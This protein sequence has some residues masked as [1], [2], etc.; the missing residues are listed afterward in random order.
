M[1]NSS[2]ISESEDA[3]ETTKM[4]ENSDSEDTGDKETPAV[5]DLNELFDHSALRNLVSKFKEE[6]TENVLQQY[7]TQI[8]RWLD[9]KDSKQE[10]T[11]SIAQFCDWLM[12]KSVSRDDAIKTF[13]QFDTDGS[14]VVETSTMIET[15]KSMSGPNL[16]GELG[17]SIR[18]MQA[19]SLT[20]GFVDVYAGDKNAVKQHAEKILK[21]L[22]RN[23][24]PSSFLPFPLLNGFN[25]T[26]NMRA[27]VLKHVF[28]NIKESGPSFTQEGVLGSGEE[29]RTISPCHSN[30]EVSSNSSESYRLTNGDPNTYWQ[31]DGTARS[32]WI[33]LHTKT[34][35]VIKT[36]SVAVASS[37]SS[38][39]PELIHIVAGKN[40]RSLR[41]LKEIRI[42]SHVTGDVVLLKN[43]KIYYPIIQINI[44]R[45]RNDGCDTRIHGI[46]TV[47]YKVMKELGINV[48]DAAAVWYIQILA[49]TVTMT[50]PLNPQLRPMVLEHT[51]R[52]LDNIPPLSLCPASTERPKFL[53]KY[54]LQEV[55][56]FVTDI[57]LSNDGEVVQ[58]GL[59]MLLSFNLARGNVGGILRTLKLLQEFPETNLPCSEL[60]RKMLQ[61]RDSCWE[62]SGHQLPVTILGT[63]G[64]KSDDN[65]GPENLL[66]HTWTSLPVEAF[67]TTEDGKTKCNIIFKSTE[68]IQIT[69][70]RLKNAQGSKGVRRGLLF[71][72]RDSTEKFNMEEHA[73]R[74]ESYDDWG[75]MEYD[76]SVQVRGAGIAGKPDNPVAYFTFEDDCN[77]IDIPVTWHPVGQYILIKLLEP[78]Q[79]KET[80]LSVAGVRFYGFPR[81]Q[82]LIDEEVSVKHPP[83]PDKKPNCNSLEII[84]HVLEFIVDLAQ[85][86]VKKGISSGKSD[87]LEF[88]DT[89]IDTLWELYT[90]FR[91]NDQEKWQSCAILMLQL[92]YCLLPV[93]SAPEGEK[94]KCS[95]EMF[96][97][98]CKVIDD[99]AVVKTSKKYRLCKQLIVEGAAM[100][101]P[102]KDARRKQLFSMMHHV[103]NLSKSPSVMLVFQSLC[104]FFSSVDPSGLLELPNHV[105]ED[106]NSQ[107]VLDIME[108]M[109]SVTYH[110]FTDT[111]DTGECHEQVIH[112]LEL[113]CSLQTSLLSWCWSHMLEEETRTDLQKEKVI[114]IAYQY[115]MSVAKKG[116]NACKLLLKQSKEKLMEF[117][118]IPNSSFLGNIIRQLIMML[119]YICD[120][121]GSTARVVLIHSFQH[122]V[123][124]LNDLAKMLPEIFPNI[125]SD[126]WST[127]QTDDIVLR[128]WEVESSHSYHNNEHET[129]VFSCPGA[130]RFIIDFDPRCETERRYDYLMFTDATGYQMKFDQRVGSNKWPRQVQ[131]TGPHVHFLFHSDNSNTEWG[132]KFKVTARGS[133]DVPLSWPF[134]LQLSLT[135]LMG[136]LCGATLASNSQAVKT[137]AIGPEDTAEQDVLRSELWTTLFRGGYMIGKL[138]HSLSGKFQAESSGSVLE[139]LLEVIDRKEG[140]PL[141]LIEKCRDH[142]KGLQVGGETIENAVIAVFT[143]LIWHT[144]QL[145]E[146]LQKYIAVS[147]GDH[148]VSDG[149]LHA[150]STAESI[151]MQLL[152]LKQKIAAAEKEEENDEEPAL[153]C[154]DKAMYLLK[155]AGLTK[156][157]LKNEMRSK[158]AKQWKKLSNKKNEKIKL[159]VTDKYPSFRLVLEFVQDPA[160]TTERVNRMI[161]ERVNHAKAVSDVYSF[162]AEFL[163]I[164]CLSV[165][166][167]IFQIPAVL[168]FQE[169]LS[170]QDGFAKHYAD[171][172]DGCGLQQEAKV[173]QAY[174]QLIRRLSEPFHNLHKHDLDKKIMPAYEFIQTCLLHLLDIEWQAYDLTFVTE[175]KLPSLYLD[176][177]KE[178][179]KMR[180]CMVDHQDED[181][182]L[183]EYEKFIKWFEDCSSGFEEW[184]E[185]NKVDDP[186]FKEE[187]RQVQMFVARFCDL[188]EVEISCDGCGV[189]LPG[190]RY[191]CLQCS[192]MDLCATCFAGGVKPEGDHGDDHEFVH[193]VYKCNMCQAFIV[194]T[195]IHCNQCEDFDLCIGCHNKGSYPKEHNTDHDITKFPMIKLKTSQ[196]SDS[197]IQ[198][199]IHQHVWLLFTVQALATGDIIHN[200]NQ[201][202]DPDYIKL[203]AQLQSQ[204][205]DAVTHCL[206]QVPDDAEDGSKDILQEGRSLEQRQEEAFAIHSQERVMGLLGAMIPADSKSTLPGVTFNFSTV[207]FIQLLFK[208]A[209]GESGHEVNTQHLAMGLLGPLLKKSSPKVADEAVITKD[210]T[211]EVEGQKSIKYLFSF[212]A[213]CLEKWGLEWACSVA[214]ILQSLYISS[215]WKMVIHQHLTH[216]VLSMTDKPDLQSIFAL[217]VMAG[218]PEVLTIGTLVHF[219]HIGTEQ[220]GVV[221]KHFPDKYQT[222][223]IDIKTRKRHTINDKFIDCLSMVTEVWDTDHFSV[224]IQTV[225]SI[226][227][228]IKTDEDISVEAV[229]VLSLSLKVL[230]N[231][232]KK[233]G[234]TYYATELFEASFIQCLVYLSSKGTD[235]SQQWLIKDLEVLS[236]MLY[237]DG[238][239]SSTKKGRHP[240]FPE[241]PSIVS[242]KTM[243]SKDK[244]SGDDKESL[245][246][247]SSSSISS[248]PSS[249]D[250]DENVAD[251]TENDDVNTIF[252]DADD[253]TKGM[254]KFFHGDCKV[255]LDVLRAIYDMNDKN[256][257]ECY[258][259]LIENLESSALQTKDEIM[260]MALKWGGRLTASTQEAPV[261]STDSEKLIDTGIY[262]HQVIQSQNKIPEKAKEEASSEDTKLMNTP[263]NDVEDDIQKQ[264]RSRSAELLKKELEKQGKSSSREYLYK[265]N[266][267]M[268]VLYAR[269]VLRKL[270]AHW[271]ESAPAITAELLGCKQVHDIPCILDLLNRSETKDVFQTVVQKVIKYSDKESLIPIACTAAQFMEEITM[272]S[273]IKQLN[274]DDYKQ[275]KDCVKDLKEAIQIPG[276]SKLQISF[277]SKCCLRQ[278]EDTLT[279][280]TSDDMQQNAKTF[281]GDSSNFINF[282]F[283]GDKLWYKFS[284]KKSPSETSNWGYKFSVTAGSILTRDSFETGYAILNNVLSTKLAL[285]LPLCRLWHTL[286]YVA[287]K[288]TG[289]NRLKSIQLMLKII[290]TQHRSSAESLSI[291][292][293]LLKP[294]W[295]LYNG[296]TK[297]GS[298]TKTLVPP[299]A[300]AL[301]ELFLQVENL[302]MEWDAVIEY[303]VALQDMEDIKKIIK[304]GILNVAAVSVSIGY[305]NIATEIISAVRKKKATKTTKN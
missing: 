8:L 221:L 226:T 62:K 39:M 278:N 83:N 76:F 27:S 191:R 2:S 114:E 300:R 184:Y 302:A 243:K 80:K 187:K 78:R 279:F 281:S 175:T 149:I 240:S 213:N 270:L 164:H 305:T 171:G 153:V 194:G 1:G 89:P 287:I 161:Q 188:L 57:A 158:A 4:D 162:T 30:I 130:N 21:Y 219:S 52:A 134:D 182:Q 32:H 227:A 110:E 210:W 45:C 280:S 7:R 118:K 235:F 180:D 3:P 40:F 148:C 37:D 24:C 292:L 259:A 15:V 13:Q 303:L 268:A 94:K 29:L 31:S 208:I 183:K 265:V 46:K 14:G 215:E 125:T 173:R 25:N 290:H 282:E 271:P 150:Y 74:F 176:V 178:T 201:Y 82:V 275:N 246:S 263:D 120:Y 237:T 185:K 286:V 44:K 123:L 232:L 16:Q 91:D 64:G 231:N 250:D 241:P 244:K 93:S 217:F 252:P 71:V 9:D 236:L 224:F 260:K 133:P 72:Y 197:M 230:S 90:A 68:F 109:L 60:L 112:L 73:K 10:E 142:N 141:R 81:K 116:T 126:H 233:L 146:D 20:P 67:Y 105:K 156:I 61:A 111:L 216:C 207:E 223:V 272:S 53:S 41:Q 135:K 269:Q 298:E 56:K 103:E 261:M 159:D 84:Q 121:C 295:N 189:T 101:F 28:K 165:S 48:G 117:F 42:P 294:L 58:E 222:L 163:R 257:S 66:N 63:D 301:T 49:S 264:K 212:G 154:K 285:A 167:G 254:F 143:S 198:A 169:L 160:W 51:R 205:I 11:I 152:Q 277:D 99:S 267:A 291:D 262:Y 119:T 43:C 181:N 289:E 138:Q 273:L 218:F 87:Y 6:I 166:N 251:D 200:N 36:L 266:M 124:D 136:R 238:V 157:Q 204:C 203:A 47:G 108:T 248:S 12:T 75:K 179:V 234:Q 144:Q 186:K 199:Y 170:Y 296:I 17:R 38:Y 245:L 115:A 34:N 79:E 128:T 127:V 86:Q 239:N 209:K 258:K 214:R 107:A 69:R 174:Y 131:F 59:H 85:D 297:D 211:S 92:M 140:A 77:E 206:Q 247:T 55:E 70:I 19:C 284:I 190:R 65:S 35:V 177:A 151:R 129:Q 132:Y 5:R 168:F 26:A 139:F 276:A 100:F 193:L 98:F 50:L 229:W 113:V 88:G 122:L 145:R 106:Y 242:L 195:R 220:T 202:P 102:D 137:L 255:P 33:R 104:R 192:D 253:D 225:K 249:S 96:E 155:F 23:R 97:H 147:I 18:M 256:T 293:S 288:Q 95:E 196:S 172:L 228:K 283:Q 54:V 304:Q 22:L 299:L 274:T